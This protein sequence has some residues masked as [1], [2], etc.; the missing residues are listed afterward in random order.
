MYPVLRDWLERQ[1]AERHRPL[2][3]GELRE[4]RKT[5]RRLHKQFLDRCRAAGVR[6]DEWPFNRDQRGYRSIQAFIY[7]F[8]PNEN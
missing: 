6:L 7:V 5:L 8:V 2:R 1:A 3:P 4:V